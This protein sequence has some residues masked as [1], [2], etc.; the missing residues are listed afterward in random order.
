[1]MTSASL[2]A[3]LSEPGPSQAA[4]APVHLVAVDTPGVTVFPG[5]SPG[6][7]RYAVRPTAST[8]GVLR[9]RAT[10]S[11]AAGSI[12]VDGRLVDD[13]LATL[14]GLVP[15]DEISVFIRDS[16]GTATYALVYLPA[17]FPLLARATPPTAATEDGHVL[18][19]L[20]KWTEPSRF[21]EV[22]VDDNG[23]PAVLR[24]QDSAMDFKLQPNGHFSTSVGATNDSAVVEYDEQWR[25]VGRHRTVGL[26]N[27][28]DHDSILLPDGSRS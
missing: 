1:M 16:A 13:G 14:T 7:E 12:R 25:V 28:D 19:T 11:D 17:D 10:T 15:G 20:G 23:V 5:F 4:Q 18:L 27:T 22:A 6:I 26:N 2:S 24:V 21:F 3:V 8:A 9:V